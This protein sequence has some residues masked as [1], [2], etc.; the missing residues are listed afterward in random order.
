MDGM[1]HEDKIILRSTYLLSESN[2]F[3]SASSTLVYCWKPIASTLSP[4]P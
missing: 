3:S 1:Q 2:C 4:C